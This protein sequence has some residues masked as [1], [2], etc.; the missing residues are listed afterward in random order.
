MN[1]LAH[2]LL[3]EDAPE[4][5]IG[6]LAADF[7]NGEALESF[8][9]AVAAGI[10]RHRAVDA[11]TDQHEVVK[12]SIR[13]LSPVQRHF[14]GI[15]VDVAYDHY[16]VRHWERF[17]AEPFDGFVAR[18]YET[19]ARDLHAAP[20]RL[21]EAFP[22][23][24]GQDWLRSYRTLD[25]IGLACARIS[26]RLTRPGRLAEAADDVR[27]HYEALDEDFRAFFPQLRA[28]FPPA[29]AAPAGL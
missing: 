28:A 4:S 19:L 27:A 6:N 11:F 22:R 14:S 17:S 9:P 16:L 1:F 7:L 13:R 21:R 15:I 26:K 3:A 20:A 18:A 12:Q 29:P 2:L 8:T 23:M 24:V 25:G 10:R 5:F